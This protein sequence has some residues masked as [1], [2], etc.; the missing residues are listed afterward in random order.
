LAS[1]LDVTDTEDSDILSARVA[2]TQNY[3]AGQ[4]FLSLASDLIPSGLTV[5]FSALT[6]ILTIRG[7]ASLT[8][9]EA[10]LKA[11]TYQN[12]SE[13]PATLT[14]TIS[15]SVTDDGG[16][17]SAPV[18]QTIEVAA[19]ADAPIVDL[20]G[21]ASGI[22]QSV[23][24]VPNIN[25]V[26]D[27]GSI[28]AS[29]LSLASG[30]L[31]TDV[32]STRLK[33]MQV[34][35]T[36]DALS[37]DR[38]YLV[39]SALDAIRAANLSISQ[40]N[41]NSSILIQGEASLAVYQ[42]LIRGIAFT[43]TDDDGSNNTVRQVTVTITDASDTVS[44]TAAIRILEATAPFANVFSGTL[45]LIGEAG[46]GRVAVDLPGVALSTQSGRLTVSGNPLFTAQNIDAAGLTN[47]GLQV[48]GNALDNIITGS[49]QDD[50]LMGGGGNDTISG[51]LGD[52]SIVY[53]LGG[54]LTGGAGKDRL[55]ISDSFDVAAATN[56]GDDFEVLDASASN[57]DI[58]ILGG[59][60]SEEIFGGR[61]N[62]TLDGGRGADYLVGGFGSDTFRFDE[63][64]DFSIPSIDGLEYSNIDV[65][66]DLSR[67]DL[68][69]LPEDLA[70]AEIEY[71]AGSW[72]AVTGIFT[73]NPATLS[74]NT[75]KATLV[76]ISQDGET[77][78]LVV[79]GLLPGQ[80][81]LNADGQIQLDWVAPAAPLSIELVSDT[82]VSPTDGLTN[83]A[84]PELQVNLDINALNGSALK[85]G[86]LVQIFK[87]TELVA[88]KILAAEDLING[89]VTIADEDYVIESLGRDGLQS[90][91][92]NIVDA[93][94]N[95]SAFSSPL[96]FNL[97]TTPTQAPGLS[98]ALASDAG[99][100]GDG[101]TNDLTPTIRVGLPT[102]VA[103]GQIIEIYDG[104]ELLLSHTV[105]LEDVQNQSVSLILSNQG[106]DLSEGDYELS[107]RIIDRA[108]NPS[109]SSETLS[110]SL[111]AT[112][113]DPVLSLS[114]SSDT[115]VLG[116][117]LTQ[118]S[119]PQ[120]QI[121]LNNV[122]VRAG[123]LLVIREGDQILETITY[124]ESDGL[125]ITV[126]LPSID[127]D[128]S[129]TITA[130]ITDQYG[131]SSSLDYTWVRDASGPVFASAEDATVE[132]NAFVVYQAQANDSNPG[133]I[134]YRILSQQGDD[135]GLFVIDA[136]TGEVSFAD[137]RLT[138][139]GEQT[140]FG[141]TVV[142]SDAAGNET[143]QEV[144]VTITEGSAEGAPSFSSQGGSAT[145]LENVGVLFQANAVAP[146][147]SEGA[148]TYRLVGTDSHLLQINESGEVTLRNGDGADFESGK[149]QYD[150]RVVALNGNKAATQDVSLAIGNVDEVS[151]ITA[152][153][154]ETRY[155][156]SSSNQNLLV[157]LA[158]G[159]LD[160]EVLDVIDLQALNTLL[161]TGAF[162]QEVSQWDLES[163]QL[164]SFFVDNNVEVVIITSL[165]GLGSLGI[166]DI[167]GAFGTDV[168]INGV[169]TNADLVGLAPVF[170]DGLD[171][172]LGLTG[173]DETG[174]GTVYLGSSLA[175]LGSLG[176]DDIAGAFGTDVIFSGLG[177]I[178]GLTGD[179]NAIT[180]EDLLRLTGFAS[181]LDVTAEIGSVADM[182]TLIDLN[183]MGADLGII[184]LDT[185]SFGSDLALDADESGNG[186]VYLGDL[187]LANIQDLGIDH[188]LSDS[189]LNMNLG[190]SGN[191]LD[192]QQLPNFGD[193]NQDGLLSQS[194]DD[195]LNV[196][197]NIS[198]AD[199]SNLGFIANE[200][201]DG[202]REFFT[203]LGESGVD[204]VNFMD[205]DAFDAFAGVLQG[206]EPVGSFESAVND[207][208]HGQDVFRHV[209][210]KIIGENEDPI[211]IDGNSRT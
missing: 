134:T 185:F 198:S 187:G 124:S 24:F 126:D 155:L 1:G 55:L 16:L 15:F 203:N 50:F 76:E 73:L 140:S 86:D 153:E 60:S 113:G 111:D 151:S 191:G 47:Q 48:T 13:N 179:I 54:T 33:S 12:T 71:K 201:S 208:N 90:L 120:L 21:I 22:N 177:D 204:V 19:I 164:G 82:G 8:T 105:V 192:I 168:M 149:T 26:T 166:D 117:A 131:N 56:L 180:S 2:I 37:A 93:A 158:Q 87:G 91:K 85:A 69:Q 98:L 17:V 75:N 65:V 83:N 148:I 125:I 18:L 59:D 51:G 127:A 100:V 112:L 62:D 89:F 52:D 95:I 99:A 183:L 176:I 121:D 49:D 172:T 53:Q 32:D 66:G 35:L 209:E 138:T 165:D 79:R 38:I 106:A 202:L 78:Y 205:R 70:D 122:G 57:T 144:A 104:S 80:L 190:S 142:A 162:R 6:G 156:A 109:S 154:L 43:S 101:Q 96:N 211:D 110:L 41:S 34:T 159:S 28:P 27:L 108:G 189:D 61:G 88:S 103:V 199:L 178:A 136:L 197:L 20:N 128:G 72:D 63:L 107:A 160:I 40:G 170:A 4:D 194:E 184:G 45:T 23:T 67:G 139:L 30:A 31:V 102:G 210:V 81:E 116:D 135:S 171:V 39:N 196:Q 7:E 3:Q 200:N 123:D 119:A 143:N 188:V 174:N 77:Y 206:N 42:S 14:R 133:D 145:V 9:Y 147:G 97:D 182:N 157:D 29:T 11:V 5:S 115:G 118:S 195:A 146:E 44:Q 137:G 74:S 175:G 92:S 193:L 58:T 132:E 129:R 46:V 36:S 94:G 167:A 169:G 25:G 150:F 181:G 68:I 152:S 130:T 64:S 161:E 207:P 10:L 141:F 186:T 163:I 114:S 84:L 173:A